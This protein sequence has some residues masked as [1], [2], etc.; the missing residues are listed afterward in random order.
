MFSNV[1]KRKSRPRKLNLL[2]LI[3]LFP[4]GMFGSACKRD[5]SES[6]PL[7]SGLDH[8]DAVRSALLKFV[9]PHHEVPTDLS[10][11]M[12]EGVLQRLP[13]V[14][15]FTSEKTL[16][17]SLSVA[18]QVGLGASSRAA[19]GGFWRAEKFAIRG[20]LNP[21]EWS[22]RG[23]TL[24]VHLNFSAGGG[25][26]FYR[27]FN[28][29]DEAK[30]QPP[31]SLMD[32]PVTIENAR[33]MRRGDLVVLPVEG[34]MLAAV[35]G[36]YLHA[37]G[38]AG[39]TIE[40]IFGSSLAGH[41]QSSL[42]ANLLIKS[43]F[44][45]HL[46]KLDDEKMRVRLFQLSERESSA[47][48]NATAT[49]PALYSLFPYSKWHLVSEFKKAESVAATQPSS[50]RIPDMLKT[51]MA[52]PESVI[53]NKFIVERQA[54]TAGSGLPQPDTELF[55]LSKRVKRN[56]AEMQSETS[57]R[58]NGAIQ[59]L[60]RQLPGLIADPAGGWSH[61]ADQELL[62]QAQVNWS[63]SRKDVKQYV[64]DY[65]F[66]L[67]DRN[68]QFAF[69]QA[70][71]GASILVTA[72]KKPTAVSRT[73]HSLLNFVVAERMARESAMRPAMP[74][75]K[76]MSASA[77]SETSESGFK[78]QIASLAGASVSENW[79]RESYSVAQ[80]PNGTSPPASSLV[81]WKSQQSY[82]FG[83][84]SERLLHSSGLISDVS[85]DPGQQSF[86]WYGFEFETGEARTAPLERFLIRSLNVLGPVGRSLGIQSRYKGEAVGPFRGRLVLGLPANVIDSIF[87][88][89]LA[90]D[91]IVWRSLANVAASYDNTFGL[92]FLAFPPGLPTSL[93][94]TTHIP[95]CE[96][97]ARLW[98]SYYCHYL[99]DKVM[100]ALRSARN[101][102]ELE[103]RNL[104]L[105]S[106][107]S[108]GFGANKLGAELLARSLV[109][110][111]LESRGRLSGSELTLWLQTRHSL[112]AAPEQNMDI[113]YG[114]SGMLSLMESL[115]P[116]W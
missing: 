75:E 63:V 17:S 20:R 93:N 85:S 76:I 48:A 10:K 18:A 22:E 66:N 43:R 36:S 38:M 115:L 8:R 54:P 87:N 71:S 60:T 14:Q 79:R 94:G 47:G 15:E 46:I 112:S 77:R 39:Q 96:N 100:P 104:F 88:P 28:H 42:R 1:Q 59:S 2:A 56:P 65:I 113:K 45:L 41:L 52:K 90:S 69:L 49:A 102:G 58:L 40:K 99:A 61:F 109:Q 13:P 16:F 6:L 3:F 97:V 70:V 110:I 33:K 27:Q 30:A 26:V 25:I 44:E 101:G 105:E 72:S 82:H 34:Q 89:K 9:N 116:P 31:A 67:A 111:A 35:D 91:E 64:A 114:D 4:A 23:R 11:L 74:V 86:Y 62:P 73:S 106:F 24:P 51:M 32:I 57:R 7:E 98:G 83:S 84:A 37:L 68:G 81:R 5:S 103:K 107:F 80:L 95:A 78:V 92:P 19:D 12:S 29:P 21:G 55:E 50:L 53:E 108:Q